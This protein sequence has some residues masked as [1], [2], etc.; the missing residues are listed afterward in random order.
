MKHFDTSHS[1]EIT[2]SIFK[3]AT[4]VREVFAGSNLSV[5]LLHIN[6]TYCIDP[7]DVTINDSGDIVIN[8]PSTLPLGIYGIQAVWIKNE[9]DLPNKFK[10]NRNILCSNVD[11]IFSIDN[12]P[13]SVGSDYKVSIISSVHTFGYDGLSAYQLAVIHRKTTKS[14]SEWA[15][16]WKQVLENEAE[17]QAQEAERQE[18]EEERE[19]KAVK[20]IAIAYGASQ[21]ATDPESVEEWSDDIPDIQSGY[22][23]WTRMRVTLG[24]DTIKDMY[25]LGLLSLANAAV[26]VTE[27]TL[28]ESQKAQVR[29]NI[30]AMTPIVTH[31]DET[32]QI[33]PD[34]L[35]LWDSVTNLSL[36]LVPAADDG[37]LHEYML[38]FSTGD[39]EPSLTISPD[40]IWIGDNELEPNKRYQVSIVNGMAVMAGV[41]YE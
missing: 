26:L 40:V 19:K 11:N 15:A 6:D 16:E 31:T 32:A 18:Q 30:G 35:N 9:N 3:G 2:W 10:N 17:R 8:T 33:K 28:T 36:T 23:M 27:Q 41:D 22:Y 13:L 24:D 29:A 37:A 1:I 38:E 4:S 5:F 7:D 21:S 34:C 12:G 39:E 25:S 14:E 20:N